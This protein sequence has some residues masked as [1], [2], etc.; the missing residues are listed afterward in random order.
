[1]AS[2]GASG[3]TTVKYGAMKQRVMSLTVV[4]AGGEIIKTSRRARK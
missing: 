3:T 2:T 1:M 4:T